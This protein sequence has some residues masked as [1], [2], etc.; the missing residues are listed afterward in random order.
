MTPHQER[1][2]KEKEELDVKIKAL[3]SFIHD[4][5][6]FDTLDLQERWRL[7]TQSHIMVQYSAILSDRINN[8]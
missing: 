5:P 8:F 1:V 2:V 4:S 3:Q 6:I 7:T